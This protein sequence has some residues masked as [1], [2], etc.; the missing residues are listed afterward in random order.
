[1]FRDRDQGRAP[2]IGSQAAPE[3]TT[4]MVKIVIFLGTKVTGDLDKN[5]GYFDP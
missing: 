4:A 1:M 3:S 5:L 2:L